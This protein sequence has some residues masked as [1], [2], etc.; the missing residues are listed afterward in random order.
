MVVLD[1]V[2]VMRNK[3]GDTGTASSSEYG[4][5]RN[6]RGG[7]DGRSYRGGVE[8]AAETKLNNLAGIRV[9]IYLIGLEV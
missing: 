1:R 6:S 9:F 7:G 3:Q 8:E 4:T 2:E 5:S